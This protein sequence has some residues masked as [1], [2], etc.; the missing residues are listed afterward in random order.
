[1]AAWKIAPILAAGNTMVLKPSEQTPLTT[2][3][4]AEVLADVLPTPAPSG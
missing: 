3:K 4:L 2:L 1:M